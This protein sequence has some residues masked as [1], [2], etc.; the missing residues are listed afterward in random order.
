MKWLLIGSGGVIGAIARYVLTGALQR[1]TGAAF[2][3]GTLVVNVLGCF[4]IGL[5]LFLSED[6]AVL[7]PEARLFVGVGMLGAFTT[8]SAYS[9]ETFALLRAGAVA[10][11][12]LYA[13][14]SVVVG[15]FAVWLGHAAG[16]ALWS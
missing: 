9:Y 12:V 7:G 14:G 13:A 4:G 5:L 15:L 10:T 2:P 16:R 3:I 1:G 11:A 6:R 8:F